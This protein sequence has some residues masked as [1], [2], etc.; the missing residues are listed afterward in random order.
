MEIKS[1][2]RFM[3]VTPRK[4]RLVAGAIR[5]MSLDRALVTLDQLHKRAG[6]Y[7]KKTIESG[8]ANAEN[9]VKL[10]RDRLYIKKL[11][12]DEGPRF[13]RWRAVSRGTAHPYA[14]NTSHIT[15]ILGEMKQETR[16]QR[17]QG[18][19]DLTVQKGKDAK[20]QVRQELKKKDYQTKIEKG[21]QQEM[22]SQK[23]TKKG[24]TTRKI[25]GK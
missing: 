9:N 23:Q 17:S 8:I 10:S 25:L 24:V 20:K 6:F 7:I 2:S 22:H 12:I 3:R 11:S 1:Q 16:E 21:K 18:L 13:K 5:N 14:K 4:A 15:V 19:K